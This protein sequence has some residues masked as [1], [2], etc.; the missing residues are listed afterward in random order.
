M[1]RWS[2]DSDNYVKS[3]WVFS[4]YVEVILGIYT[5]DISEVS[6]LHVCGGDP[7]STWF[8]AKMPKCSPRMW[9]WSLM[10]RYEFHDLGVFSTY[11]EVILESSFLRYLLGGVLHVCGGDPWTLDP[12]RFSSWCSPRMWRWSWLLEIVQ[13]LLIV[14]STYVEVILYFL[15]FIFLVECVLH[16]CGGDPQP[17]PLALVY[18]LCSPRMWR[19]SLPLRYS[20]RR[21][22][23]FSTYVEVIPKTRAEVSKTYRVLHVCGGDPNTIKAVKEKNLCSPRMWRWSWDLFVVFKVQLGFSTYVE[24]ILAP[25]CWPFSMFSVLHVCG[26]D[27]NGYGFH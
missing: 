21:S 13:A 25:A 22:L 23:V 5:G 16:V 10:K 6:V 14:F 7:T 15:L 8:S 9:R 27:P 12:S 4:T 18:A 19:W 26:G 3:T 2:P 20:N 17:L 24:V 1:W 11:V